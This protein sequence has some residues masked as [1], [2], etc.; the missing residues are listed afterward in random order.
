[1][2]RNV[3]LLGTSCGEHIENIR[4]IVGNVTENRWEH[5]GNFFYYNSK[6]KPILPLILKLSAWANTPA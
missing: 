2:G 1:M 6:P 3:V 4:N 5:D